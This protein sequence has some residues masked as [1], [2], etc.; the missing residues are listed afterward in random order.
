V[1]PRGLLAPLL[2]WTWTTGDADAIQIHACD[3]ERIV[4]VTGT[5]ARPSVLQQTGGSFIRP[6]DPQD[7]WTN[8][9]QHRRGSDAERDARISSL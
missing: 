7:I 2:Q 6:P 5:F 4:L 3:D 8:G 9:H 1:F